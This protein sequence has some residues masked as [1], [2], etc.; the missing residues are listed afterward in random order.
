[1]FP[2]SVKLILLSFIRDSISELVNTV[3]N[4]NMELDMS[5]QGEDVVLSGFSYRVKESF[6]F[7]DWSSITCSEEDESEDEITSNDVGSSTHL[8]MYADSQ[9]SKNWN[10]FGMG[11]VGECMGF[12]REVSKESS[13]KPLNELSDKIG[14]LLEEV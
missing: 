10:Q 9:V 12:G 14:G 11:Q 7:E 1:M 13:L 3:Q 8:D 5:L 4:S 2:S 6:E